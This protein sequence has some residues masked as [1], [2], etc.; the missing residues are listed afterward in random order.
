MKNLSMGR[1][2]AQNR[3]LASFNDCNCVYQTFDKIQTRPHILACL[4]NGGGR[5]MVGIKLIKHMFAGA[6]LLALAS[7]QT[8]LGGL[9]GSGAQNQLPPATDGSVTNIPTA[10]NGEIVGTGTVRVAMLLPITGAGNPAKIAKELRNA[11]KMAV[12]DIGPERIQLVIKDTK[13]QSGTSQ[14]LANEAVREGASLVL[15][16]LLSSNVSAAAGITQPANIPMVAFSTDTNVARRG[17][18]L[19]SFPPQ[20][21]A[22]RVL[23][24]AASKG[25]KSILAILP[26]GAYG[27]VVEAELRRTVAATGGQVVAVG[28]YSPQGDASAILSSIQTA[29]QGVAAQ[30]AAADAIYVPYFANIASAVVDAFDSNGVSI[31][32]KQILGSG[33]WYTDRSNKANLRGAWFAERNQAEF[34]AFVNRYRGIYSEEPGFNAGLGYDAVSLAIGLSGAF[35][36]Q[37]FTASNLEN[38]NGFSGVTGLFRFNSQGRPE[39]GLAVYQYTGGTPT[40]LEQAPSTFTQNF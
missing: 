20:L 22:R 18:Y 17:V 8:P 4:E 24:Y 5:L 9:T 35:G 40:V 29:V 36:T 11:A 21:D 3:G 37:A 25:K 30:A 39:R 12:N 7:C 23:T 1:E 13:G 14:D 32:G 10:A 26:E 27:I 6:V 33:L 38:L 2:K 19:N 16:P 31:T 34:N 15:G 28:K